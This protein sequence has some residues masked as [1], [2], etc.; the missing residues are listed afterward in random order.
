MAAARGG[1]SVSS[2]SRSKW[3]FTLAS[4]RLKRLRRQSVGARRRGSG[5]WKAEAPDQR[6][7]AVYHALF[8]GATRS[9]VK[10]CAMSARPW[11]PWYPNDFRSKTLDLTT[12]QIGAYFLLLSIAWLRPDVAIPNDMRGLKRALDNCAQPMHGRTFNRLIPPLLKR[13]FELGPDGKWHNKRL[14]EEYGKIVKKS[15]LARHNADKRWRPANNINGLSNAKAML[16]T[17]HIDSSRFSDSETG[18]P[19]TANTNRKPQP[20]VP[21][22]ELATI[23]RRKGWTET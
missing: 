13:Y 7:A 6:K 1:K 21:T 22:D 15:D 16:F 23:V 10:G 5:G 4:Y 18:P 14:E 19:P 20:T 9:A 2:V 8:L 17:P 3:F 11:L 12:E